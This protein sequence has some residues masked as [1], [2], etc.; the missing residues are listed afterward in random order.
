MV[1]NCVASASIGCLFCCQ[2]C[3]AEKLRNDFTFL[4]PAPSYA[5]EGCVEGGRAGKLQYVLEALRN[6]SFYQQAAEHAEVHFVRTGRGERIPIVWVRNSSSPASGSPG[7]RSSGQQPI[8]L[9]HC[10]GNATDIGMMMA[11][12]LEMTRQLGCEVV[13]VEYSGYGA[14]SGKP[15][16]SNT[17]ADAEAAYNFLLSSGIAPERIVVYGQSVG[18]G[19]AMALAARRPM[20]GCV[21]HSPMLS[22]IRVIDPQPDSCCR[23][24]CVF[25]CF[26]FF[27]NDQHIKSVNCP[28]FVMHGRMDDVI[29]LYHGLR[30][31]DAAPKNCRWPGYF[32]KDAGHNDIIERNSAAYF[33]EVCAFLRNVQERVHGGSVNCNLPARSIGKPAQME[34]SEVGKGPNGAARPYVEPT[35][36][37]NDG[38]YENIRRA[39]APSGA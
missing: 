14:S 7:N 22:G 37:P 9:L 27:R 34:M 31:S 25:C 26:D 24:S 10:H 1:S 20:G 38:R 19:P 39:G 21:L 4:P 30:L 29:P 15:S 13:G 17:L 32:P 33:G 28:V 5:V 35:V 3:N 12:Y 36:G 6:F 8:V 18:S 23:P 2:G 11:A 16:A